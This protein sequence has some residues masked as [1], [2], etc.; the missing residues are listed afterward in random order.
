MSKSKKQTEKDNE[1]K[2]PGKKPDFQAYQISKPESDEKPRWS[3]IGV[4]FRHRDGEGM[5]LLLDK[6]PE[7]GRVTL[8]SIRLDKPE[9]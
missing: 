1:V 8:R 4:G 5:N 6:L 9:G 2:T 7:N 3:K